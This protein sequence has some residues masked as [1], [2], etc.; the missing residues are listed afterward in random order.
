MSVLQD[1]RMECFG[2][3]LFDLE[4]TCILRSAVTNYTEGG[5]RRVWLTALS[6]VVMC[7]S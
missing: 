2:V 5:E 4:V 6:S 7:A 1:F 3:T